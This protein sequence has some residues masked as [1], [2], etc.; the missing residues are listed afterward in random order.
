MKAFILQFPSAD[1]E[2]KKSVKLFLDSI[3]KF[4]LSL[5]LLIF[6]IQSLKNH[7]VVFGFHCNVCCL[8]GNDDFPM[9]ITTKT[10]NIV[11]HVSNNQVHERCNTE[12]NMKIIIYFSV[13]FACRVF[14]SNDYYILF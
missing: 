4:F 9:R 11:L 10:L 3:E 13:W 14:A 6:L 7:A 5:S 12:D 8:F 1:L 2:N